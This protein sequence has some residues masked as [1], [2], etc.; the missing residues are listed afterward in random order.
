MAEGMTVH[1]VWP[2]IDELKNDPVSVI[3]ETVEEVATVVKETVVVVT[4]KQEE[5]APVKVYEHLDRLGSYEDIKEALAAYKARNEVLANYESINSDFL[6]LLSVGNVIKDEIIVEDDNNN[7][8]YIEK[9]FFTGE[10]ASHGTSWMDY[11]NTL[12]DQNIIMY[13]HYVYPFKR[14]EGY[15]LCFTNLHELKDQSKYEENKYIT[16]ETLDEKRIYEVVYVYYYKLNEPNTGRYFYTSYPD[17]DDMYTITDL[18]DD[19]SKA[20]F[21]D[22]GKTLSSEDNLLSLQTCVEG[23]DELRLIVIAK[24]INRIKFKEYKKKFTIKQ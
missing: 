4:V 20:A 6:G 15:P 21:Y 7:S 3:E 2:R 1:F 5:K 12:D 11:R 10:Y 14:V 24:E 17:G 18:C 9:D 8:E 19:A 16:F 23:H 13:G 22:S